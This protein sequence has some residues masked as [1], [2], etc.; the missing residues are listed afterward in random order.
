MARVLKPGTAILRCAVA[1]LVFTQKDREED[2]HQE[3][4]D[5]ER[6]GPG[7]E[8]DEACYFFMNRSQW[9]EVGPGPPEGALTSREAR[10]GKVKGFTPCATQ[11]VP[12]GG[13]WSHQ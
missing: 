7:G 8:M 2:A 9:A 11:A 12:M 5:V 13:G 3:I 6:S 4:Q 10:L 1:L